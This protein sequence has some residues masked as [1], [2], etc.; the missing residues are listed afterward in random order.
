VLQWRITP[1]AI[2]SI[3]WRAEVGG[4]YCDNPWQAPLGIV[5]AFNLIAGYTAEPIV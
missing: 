4:C 5:I 2:E 3:V 1:S